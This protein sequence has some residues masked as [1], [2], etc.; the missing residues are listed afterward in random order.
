MEIRKQNILAVTLDVSSD[1]TRLD[2]S[3]KK[4]MS[5]KVL[6][7]WLLKNCTEEF[8][9]LAISDIMN[10]CIEGTPG[11]INETVHAHDS[12][13]G[14]TLTAKKRRNCLSSYIC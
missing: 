6:L 7:A 4:L 2:R 9:S 14:C 3:A 12:N 11:I 13:S 10:Y 8:K 5:Q 1:I